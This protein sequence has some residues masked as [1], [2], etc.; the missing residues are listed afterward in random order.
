MNIQKILENNEKGDTYFDVDLENRMT[1]EEQYPIYA[2][3]TDL[4]GMLIA[5]ELQRTQIFR[6]FKGYLTFG[7]CYSK[8]KMVYNVVNRI[9]PNKFSITKGAMRIF[10]KETQSLYGFN[11]D[12]PLE[13]HTWLQL[14]DCDSN[15]PYIIDM[16]L[17]GVILRGS[18]SGDEYGKFIVGMPP[19]AYIGKTGN[20]Y[21]IWYSAKEVE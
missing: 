7:D 13:Y 5:Q 20:D 19:F 2:Q 9:F 14:K 8:A 11:W 1:G 6:S 10:C 12:P 3:K 4:G 17:P 18:S 15:T 16:A 21:G